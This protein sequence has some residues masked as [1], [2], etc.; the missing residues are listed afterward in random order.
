MERFL[1]LSPVWQ[2]GVMIARRLSLAL[3]VSA[4]GLLATATPA[5]A[6]AHLESSDPAE[7]AA[8]A[9]APAQ[10]TLVFS[11][12]VTLP[13]APV[14]IIGPDNVTWTVGTVAVSGPTV[15]APITPT[16]PAGAYVLAYRVIS[17]DG[18][19]VAGS[20]NFTLTTAPA[21]PTTST[22]VTTPPPTTTTEAPETE[23]AASTE[24][25]GGVPA[26]VWIVVAVLVIAAA[27]ALVLRT[28]S[29]RS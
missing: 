1:G 21:P 3:L 29:R 26:W 19:T 11:E 28:R 9:T 14:E 16:G 2:D 25:S 22:T 4:L 13:D 24:D 27:V 8:L 12:P 7:G 23:P 10:V 6:H 18:D 20:V 5:L 15:T 17:A